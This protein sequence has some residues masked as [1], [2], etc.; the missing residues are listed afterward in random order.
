MTI[1]YIN[2][3]LKRFVTQI[4]IGQH[5]TDPIMMKR[6]VKQKD[7][8]SP[9]LVNRVIDE[10]IGIVH[11]GNIKGTIG[12]DDFNCPSMAFA[13]DIILLCDKKDETE[14]QINTA[15]KFLKEQDLHINPGKC[16]CLSSLR[17]KNILVSRS[18][19][20]VNIDKEKINIITTICPM[21]YLCHQF[22]LGG[23]NRFPSVLKEALLFLSILSKILEKCRTRQILFFLETNNLDNECR[24]W[25]RK[26]RN[27]QQFLFYVLIKDCDNRKILRKLGNIFSPYTIDFPFFKSPITF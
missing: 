4:S 2:E 13:D 8:F 11:G 21:K 10:L 17:N 20:F 14:I 15:V 25:I 24:F 23:M 5:S 9:M 22:N 26:G 12:E 1:N 27:I 3:D 16:K 19:P 7:P 6:G 18:R